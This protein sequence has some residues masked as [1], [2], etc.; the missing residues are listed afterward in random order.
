MILD[1][2][3]NNYIDTAK[4]GELQ[5]AILAVC[6]CLQETMGCQLR[7]SRGNLGGYLVC[8]N[9]LHVHVSMHKNRSKEMYVTYAHSRPGIDWVGDRLSK[10][11]TIMSRSKYRRPSQ[12][13]QLSGLAVY[14]RLSYFD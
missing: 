11:I 12:S 7:F 4:T 2:D 1:E 10:E 5:K 3:R 9:E 8:G 13:A 6:Y 14:F